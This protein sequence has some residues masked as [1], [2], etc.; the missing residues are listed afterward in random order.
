MSTSLRVLIADDH[1]I[2]RR[3]VISILQQMPEVIAIEEAD[4][5]QA[6]LSMLHRARPDLLLLDLAMPQLDGLSVLKAA[7]PQYPG[8]SI[9]VVT[10]YRNQVYLDNALAFGANGFV[11]KDD[12]DENLADCIRKVRAGGVFISPGFD[13]PEPKLPLV[14]ADQRAALSLLTRMECKVLVLVA[15]YLTSKEIA[16][17][18]NISYRTV[19]NHR[20]NISNK[21][22]MK[23]IHKLADFARQYKTELDEII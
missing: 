23:G 10:S 13:N 22:G 17:Q 14:E 5:G 16:L 20:T 21:L 9:I 7:R 2:F 12:I 15:R 18:L 4:D 6:A 19:Q 1:P 11:L 8:L 3:G